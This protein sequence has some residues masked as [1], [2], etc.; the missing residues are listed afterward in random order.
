MSSAF[1]I[2]LISE[3]QRFSVSLAGVTYNITLRWNQPGQ[4]WGMD[5]ADI[6]DVPIIQGVPLVTGANLLEQFDYLGIG[7]RMV[8][9]TDYNASAP[10]TSSNLGTQSHLYF[11]TQ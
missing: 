1:E 9:T 2:P 11:V 10:P 3:P 8:V 5:I 6:N 7:G 4:F